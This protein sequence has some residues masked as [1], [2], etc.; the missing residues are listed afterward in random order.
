MAERKRKK[1]SRNCV[2]IFS[3]FLTELE[4]MVIG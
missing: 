4:T 1:I 3:W 2:S